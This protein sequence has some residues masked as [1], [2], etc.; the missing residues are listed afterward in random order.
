MQTGSYNA[1]YSGKVLLLLKIKKMGS[2][3]VTHLI[4]K[5]LNRHLHKIKILTSR[6]NY[7]YDREFL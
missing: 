4:D 3:N 1:Q 7:K 6:P 5:K 2:P